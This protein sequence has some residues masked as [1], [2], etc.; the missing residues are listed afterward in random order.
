M[1]PWIENLFPALRQ[2]LG[3]QNT[4]ID[5]EKEAKT[6]VEN[7]LEKIKKKEVI[8]S[9]I[10][11]DKKVDKGVENMNSK[12]DI[13]DNSPKESSLCFSIGTLSTAGTGFCS[14]NLEIE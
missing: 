12:E 9:S 8:N 6:T 4:K 14:G 2:H 10:E 5:S 13:K 3:L 7:G 11:A 1:E